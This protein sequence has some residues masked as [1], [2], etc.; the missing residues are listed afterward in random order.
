MDGL[1]EGG[2]EGAERGIPK[3]ELYSPAFEFKSSQK[4]P[5]ASRPFSSTSVFH[6]LS[7]RTV[8]I[9]PSRL[10]Q[11]NG[12]GMLLLVSVKKRQA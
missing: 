2:R 4:F 5:R 3:L 8:F 10:S 12:V 11:L 1:T 7:I 9:L 6:S